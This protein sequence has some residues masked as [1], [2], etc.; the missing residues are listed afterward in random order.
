MPPAEK[1]KQTKEY[2]FNTELKIRAGIT[3]VNSITAET[4]S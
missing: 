4:D 1:A 2:M 3:D